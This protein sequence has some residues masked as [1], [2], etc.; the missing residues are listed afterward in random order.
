MAPSGRRGGSR[1]RPTRGAPE[2][3]SARAVKARRVDAESS[4]SP[5]A[6]FPATVAFDDAFAGGFGAAVATLLELKGRLPAGH[7]LL[8]KPKKKKKA[9]K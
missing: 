6:R 5:A 4:S 2:A 7:P 1:K 3:A 9:K 8:Q